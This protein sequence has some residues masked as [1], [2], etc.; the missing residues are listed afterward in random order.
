M[1][2]NILCLLAACL[3][4]SHSLSVLEQWL[5]GVTTYDGA[6]ALAAVK[7]SLGL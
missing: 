2:K 4:T 3:L 1:S 7:G 5:A 6:E